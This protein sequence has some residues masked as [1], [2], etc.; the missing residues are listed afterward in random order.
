MAKPLFIPKPNTN[1]LKRAVTYTENS[2]VELHNSSQGFDSKSE[3]PD[4]LIVNHSKIK[5]DTY[6]F[7]YFYTGN[8]MNSV[9]FAELS[10]FLKAT[11]TQHSG[12]NIMGS[13]FS[14]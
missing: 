10:A 6:H 13:T 1:F 4:S 9:P 3:P 14:K 7:L 12:H 5:S 11:K 2:T 8:N